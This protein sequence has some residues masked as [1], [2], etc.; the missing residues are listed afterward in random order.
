MSDA[1]QFA[2]ML[3]RLSNEQLFQFTDELLQTFRTLLSAAPNSTVRILKPKDLYFDVC[4]YLKE[5]GWEREEKG[6]GWWWKPDFQDDLL[7]M[8][9][10][11]DLQLLAD[12]IDLRVEP[13]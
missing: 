9:E 12:G 2:T 11:L 5:A 1:D 8:G 6:S 4:Q 3:K 7:Q 13:S 10:A